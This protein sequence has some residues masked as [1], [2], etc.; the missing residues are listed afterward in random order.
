MR[1]LFAFST[2]VLFGLLI[3]FQ[4][5]ITSC[6]KEITTRDTVIVINKDTTIQIKIDT[7]RLVKNAVPVV[8]PGNN[9]TFNLTSSSD[10]LLLSG[11][12]TDAD[13]PI[14]GYLWSQVSGPNTALITNP[15]SATTYITKLVSGAYVFQLMALDSDGAVGIKK[16]TITVVQQTQILTLQ[17]D[18]A[19]GQ[20][21]LVAT[22]IG[23]GGA[24]ASANHGYIA[25][26]NMMHWTYGGNGWGFL[27]Q[28]LQMQL[29]VPVESE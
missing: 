12:A 29:P 2:I 19:E 20:D 1:K 5:G 8:N 25:E 17:P 13:N 10:S 15:G 27:L 14:V 22:R 4:V 26:L 18:G 11:S 9:A 24:N 3:I 23:D 6:T 7:I 16:V 21:A 28:L